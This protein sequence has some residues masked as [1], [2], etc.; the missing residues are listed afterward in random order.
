MNKP[1]TIGV[2]DF[3][4]PYLRLRE[5]GVGYGE[6]DISDLFPVRD[7]AVQCSA[8]TMQTSHPAFGLVRSRDG[9]AITQWQATLG[10]DGVEIERVH[11]VTHLT[12]HVQGSEDGPTEWVE[13]QV[14]TSQTLTG[15]RGR[16]AF[17]AMAALV[18]QL[19]DP[20]ETGQDS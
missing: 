2:E 16:R 17:E 19:M 9:S 18:G 5:L 3:S 7:P 10:D 8:Y 20:P 12:A 15:E 14:I 4:R 11:R 13:Q 6:Q 1:N